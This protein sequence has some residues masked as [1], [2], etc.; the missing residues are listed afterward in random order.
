MTFIGGRKKPVGII[1][2]EYFASGDWKCPTSPTGGHLW[3]CNGEPFV[4][5]ICGKVKARPAKV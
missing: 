4:C 2:K 5:K 1:E 3:D